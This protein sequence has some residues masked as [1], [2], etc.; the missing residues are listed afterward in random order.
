MAFLLCSADDFSAVSLVPD[1][2]SLLPGVPLVLLAA[3]LW[4]LLLEGEL[5]DELDELVSLELELELV[6]GDFE[7]E[8][9]GDADEAAPELRAAALLALGEAFGAALTVADGA[10][11]APVDGVIEVAGL[12][13]V[14]GEAPL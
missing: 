6:E 11:E 3:C 14:A 2:A 12:A 10:A 7:V 5:A 1:A 13:L 9:C 4:L 8:L